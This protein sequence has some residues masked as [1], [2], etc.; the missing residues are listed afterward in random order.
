MRTILRTSERALISLAAD[1]LISLANALNEVC[2]GIDIGESEFE[3][4][5]GVSRHRL[6]N[7]LAELDEAPRVPEEYGDVITIWQDSGAIMIRAINVWGDP[8]EL[9]EA[10]ASNVSVQLSQVIRAAS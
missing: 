10:E 8:V 4:R 2:N 9:S 7:L 3:T 1:E 5:L 6:R